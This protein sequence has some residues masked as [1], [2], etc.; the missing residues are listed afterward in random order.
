MLGH[1]HEY[2][3]YSVEQPV[4]H[5]RVLSATTLKAGAITGR[6]SYHV[7]PTT[8]STSMTPGW[9]SYSATLPPTL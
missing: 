8:D 9:V 4:Q 6:A 1:A 7:T 3:S 5:N 2:T